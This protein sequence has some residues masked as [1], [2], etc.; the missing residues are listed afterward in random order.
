[1]KIRLDSNKFYDVEADAL[2]VS[3][4]ENEKPDDGV[5]KVLIERSG[6]LLE[7]IIGTDEMRGK[8]GDCVFLHQAGKIR[9]RR[10]LLI[11][12]G[13]RED[14]SLETLVKY[15]GSA[16]RLLRSKGARSIAF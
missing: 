7:Q 13:K 15:T 1:M 10:L 14:F 5:L 8:T 11:G 12:A 4:Y 9:A 2:V 16:A 3:I 6:G